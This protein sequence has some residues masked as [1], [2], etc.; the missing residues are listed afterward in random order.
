MQCFLRLVGAQ[1]A[2]RASRAGGLDDGW[3]FRA[4]TGVRRSSLASNMT[5]V[6][7]YLA[8]VANRGTR[9][10]FEVGRCGTLDCAWIFRAW[11]PTYRSHLDH[12]ISLGTSD[13]DGEAN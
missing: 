6:T 5:G 4:L 8:D 9:A 12:M 1:V 13:R 11:T 2:F 3:T 7:S 10:A